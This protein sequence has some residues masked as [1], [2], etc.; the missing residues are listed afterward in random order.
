MLGTFPAIGVTTLLC[1]LVALFLRLNLPAMQLI[2]S[3]AYPLQFGLLLP[4]AELGAVLL[5]VPQAGFSFREIDLL[6]REG[7]A[8]LWES[9]S[10]QLGGAALA[11]ALIMLPSSLLCYWGFLRLFQR[12]KPL[13]ERTYAA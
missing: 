9:F 5:D 2:N 12:I 7:L 10:E 3:L 4:F 8:L 6:S 1:T 11:W 13:G